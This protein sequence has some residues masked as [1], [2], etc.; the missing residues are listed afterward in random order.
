[1]R[2]KKGFTI[3]ELI[4]V[5]LIIS[6]LAAIAVPA[7]MGQ[8]NKAGSAEAIA[9]M[10]MI[11]KEIQIATQLNQS[12]A[13]GNATALPGINS[14][15][16]AGEYYPATGYVLTVNSPTNYYIKATPKANATAL[17][18]WMDDE[19]NILWSLAE[20]SASLQ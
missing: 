10:G 17:D 8:R 15:D 1:M 2:N 6:A 9:A 11:R 14:N 4:V 3:I 19:G 18:V 20:A 7:L 16:L 5:I 12:V 13:S